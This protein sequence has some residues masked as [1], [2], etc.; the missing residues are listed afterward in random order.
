VYN[1]SVSFSAR[2]NPVQ[3]PVKIEELDGRG[4]RATAPE[5]FDVCAEAPTREQVLETIQ[6]LLRDRI[7]SRSDII[8]VNIGPDENPWDRVYGMFADDPLFDEWQQ[9]IQENRDR[10]DAEEGIL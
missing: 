2:R 9:A 10:I 1:D 7:E 8:F 5:P 6:N 4:F 3:V